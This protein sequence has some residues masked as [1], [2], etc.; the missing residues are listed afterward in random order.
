M[1]FK[2]LSSNVRIAIHPGSRTPLL[3]SQSS[4]I[5]GSPSTVFIGDIPREVS[6]VELYEYIRRV[7]GV[8][9]DFDLV[10][11]R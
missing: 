11:K 1:I 4:K 10:L 6:Q 9:C 2:Q 3:Q 7:L 8:E 5:L